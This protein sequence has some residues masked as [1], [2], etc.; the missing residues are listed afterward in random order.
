MNHNLFNG[1]LYSKAGETESDPSGTPFWKTDK[2]PATRL[3]RWVYCYILSSSICDTLYHFFFELNCRWPVPMPCWRLSD[4][5]EKDK[6]DDDVGVY[7][8]YSYYRGE[9]IL[10]L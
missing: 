4:D 3:N 1:I 10:K 8:E 6:P 2:D 9:K 7:S 5:V